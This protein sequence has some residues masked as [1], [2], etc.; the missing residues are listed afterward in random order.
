MYFRFCLIYLL[1][2]KPPGTTFM[3]KCNKSSTVFLWVKRFIQAKFASP[4][5]ILLDPP[6]Y[7]R[8]NREKKNNNYFSTHILVSSSFKCN[9]PLI[10]SPTSISSNLL[11]SFHTLLSYLSSTLL[12]LFRFSE[13]HPEE[14]VRL[15]RWLWR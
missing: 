5:S 3:Y 14:E 11:P 12:L 13:S 10:L 7:S 6:L 4:N 15:G 8:I 9:K 1:F 2:C